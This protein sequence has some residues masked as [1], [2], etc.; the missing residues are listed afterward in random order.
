[1]WVTGVQTCAL[2]ISAMAHASGANVP[3]SHHDAAHV[4][5]RLQ[6]PRVDAVAKGASPAVPVTTTASAPLLAVDEDG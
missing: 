5:C 4:S 3:C 6:P 2:P 1:M